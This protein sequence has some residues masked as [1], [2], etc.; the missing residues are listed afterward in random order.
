MRCGF[1]YDFDYYMLAYNIVEALYR[2]RVS[3]YGDLV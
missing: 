1:R 2:V 3:D